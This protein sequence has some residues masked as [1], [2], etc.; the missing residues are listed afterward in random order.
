VT[1][2]RPWL[3]LALL[4]ATCASTWYVQDLE[5][6]A[7]L[8][9]ILV[10]HEMGHF[11]AARHHRV[12]ASL[13]YFIPMPFIA[14]GTLGA[15]IKMEAPIQRRL[16]LIDVGAAGPL[17]GFVV[18]LPLLAWGLAASPVGPI[19]VADGGV[20]VM[21]GNSLLYLGLKLALK[22]RLLPDAAGHDVQLTS[23]AF[24]AWVGLLVTFINLIPVG[25]LDGGHI[26][27]S[28]FGNRYERVVGW[29][30][31]LLP[32]VALG[33]YAHMVSEARGKGLG[34]QDA[35]TYGVSG[36][37]PW[38]V[39]AV[40]L[41]V[42]RRYAGGRYHPPVGDDGLPASRRGLFWLMVVLFGLL[43]VPVPLR[44]WLP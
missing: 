4:V 25:Q 28:Y 41:A 36:G 42:M 11:L 29:L 27:V 5:F 12:P 22:G 21:E 34:W 20:A 7:T 14:T 13:P 26:A 8:M 32:V 30:H 1:L 3:H 10:T 38:L 18:A 39:W 33:L 37:A 44:I 6:A 40:I 9:A 35:L 43:V 23:M 24:A 16:A 15:I 2:R 19:E 17:A 31:R